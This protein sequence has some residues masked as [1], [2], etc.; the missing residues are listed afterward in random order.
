MKVYVTFVGV[1]TPYY[2]SSKTMVAL[3]RYNGRILVKI[4]LTLE[5]GN[6]NP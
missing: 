1:C 3:D 6:I 5:L 2:L 4:I